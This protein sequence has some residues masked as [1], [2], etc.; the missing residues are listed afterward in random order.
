MF[1][2]TALARGRIG[3]RCGLIHGE[4]TPLA[5][6][7]SKTELSPRATISLPHLTPINS[8][9]SPRRPLSPSQLL[10]R[11]ELPERKKSDC[12]SQRDVFTLLRR[13]Y[14][15]FSPSTGGSTFDQ[16]DEVEQVSAGAEENEGPL[17]TATSSED[18]NT[19]GRGK[20][21]QVVV[22]A[23][24]SHLSPRTVEDVA[25][26]LRRGGAP[27]EL[28]TSRQIS[29]LEASSRPH[30]LPA[31]GKVSSSTPSLPQPSALPAPAVA[32]SSAPEPSEA[33][34]VHAEPPTTLKNM[35]F[36][37]SEVVEQQK[38]M[39]PDKAFVAPAAAPRPKTKVALGQKRPPPNQPPIPRS[40]TSLPRLPPKPRRVVEQPPI[41]RSLTDRV[42]EGRK[43]NKS[44]RSRRFLP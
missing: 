11:S 36:L 26:S 7:L 28:H 23:L 22:S 20:S 5:R 10:R 18:V 30:A 2:A 16:I 9:S 39:A 1:I 15:F 21:P 12:C 43:N 37:N 24:F 27:W 4:K 38:Y 3:T 29:G 33:E 44:P 8:G 41:I 14:T 25:T 31:L 13:F 32:S 35:L 34:L 42:S 17:Q 19:S 40:P 6:K